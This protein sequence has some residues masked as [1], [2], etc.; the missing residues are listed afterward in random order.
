MTKK[1][2]TPSPTCLHFLHLVALTGVAALRGGHSVSGP[3]NQLVAET[4]SLCPF[5]HRHVNVTIG[6]AL[7]AEDVVS[8]HAV[9]LG[10]KLHDCLA[11]RG[12]EGSWRGRGGERRQRVEEK[13][14]RRVEK[15]RLRLNNYKQASH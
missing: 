13:V 14:I 9:P 6:R 4:Q 1:K 12:S 7:V 8:A 5:T 11:A 10:I 3:V 15:R 2:R